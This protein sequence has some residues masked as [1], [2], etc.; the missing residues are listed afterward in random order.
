MKAM[1]KRFPRPGDWWTIQFGFSRMLIVV[2]R[3]DPEFVAW[4]SP[5][6]CVDAQKEVSLAVWSTYGPSFVGESRK[7]WWWRFLPWRNLVNPY[8]KPKGWPL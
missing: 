6:W 2:L 8:P 1:V 7:R 4:M 3:S 5:K